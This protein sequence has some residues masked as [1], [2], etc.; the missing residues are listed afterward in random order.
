MRSY[1]IIR[2]TPRKISSAST[3]INIIDNI[4]IAI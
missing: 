2:H 4:L 3:D 1:K